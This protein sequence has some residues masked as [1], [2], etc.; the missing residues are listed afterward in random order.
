MGIRDSEGCLPNLVTGKV[1]EK[2]AVTMCWRLLFMLL[3][4]RWWSC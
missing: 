3:I 2:G 4:L 1:A